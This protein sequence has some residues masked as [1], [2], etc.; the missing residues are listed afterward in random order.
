MS[1]A[2]SFGALLLL[3]AGSAAQGPVL[4]APAANSDKTPV[5]AAAT[6]SA[7]ALPINI[8][9]VVRDKHGDLV[10]NLTRDSFALQ[11]DDRPQTIRD[12]NLDKD[13]PLTV[14][15]LVDTS[16]SHR[17]VIDDE[18]AASSAFV[19]DILTGTPDS[20]KAFVVQ[21]ARQIDLLQDVTSAKP[22]LQAA[23]KQLTSSG[24]PN[25]A[26]VADVHGYCFCR[27]A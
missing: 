23:I 26:S 11:V 2:T 14:G 15:L 10:Q 20:N 27:G 1:R 21:F 8:P 4:H 25:Q 13:L 3:V 9:V 16:M 5:D 17:N 24:N 22:M 19:D 7:D 18:R 6:L 12:F